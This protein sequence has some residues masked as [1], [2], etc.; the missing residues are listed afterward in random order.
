MPTFTSNDGL[1]I[2]SDEWG[3]ADRRALDNVALGSFLA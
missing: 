2:A 3:D 1:T